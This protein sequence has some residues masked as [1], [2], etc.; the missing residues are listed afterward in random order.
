MIIENARI[1]LRRLLPD[2]FC[3]I[4]FPDRIPFNLYLSSEWPTIG[5][6]SIR[7]VNYPYINFEPLSLDI[8]SDEIQRKI[9]SEYTTGSDIIP[10]SLSFICHNE[11][12]S[13]DIKEIMIE[14]FLICSSPLGRYTES[15]IRDLFNHIG[16]IVHQIKI[17]T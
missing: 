5:F 12:R 2:I 4:A 3:S 10:L 17:I 13:T 6:A 1:D 11:F 15:S 7:S 9:K 14:S 16:N 8:E